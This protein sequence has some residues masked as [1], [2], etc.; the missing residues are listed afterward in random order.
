MGDRLCLHRSP[1]V[2]RDDG[3]GNRSP[4]W[5][6]RPGGRGVITIGIVYGLEG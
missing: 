2:N 5:L 6:P 1:A 4:A 3:D